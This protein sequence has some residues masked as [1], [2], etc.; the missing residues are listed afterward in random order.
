MPLQDNAPKLAPD[1][2]EKNFSDLY[3]PMAHD[4]AMAEASRCLFCYDAPCINACP[5]HIDIPKF[6]KQIATRN[7]KGSARTILAANLFGGSCAR[8]CP[9]EALCE[10]DCVMNDLHKKPIEIGRLQRFATDHVFGRGEH[11]KL[12]QKGASNGKKVAVIGAGPAGLS[13]AG[14]LAQLG[15]QV[16]VYDA[17]PKPGGLNTYAIAEYKMT[18]DTALKETEIVQA[19]GVTLKQGVQVGKD[20]SLSDLEKDND[21]VF[22]GIGL[23]KTAPLGIEGENMPGV[24]DA[25]TFIEQVKSRRFDKIELGRRVIV[26]GAGNTAVDATTQAKRLGAEKV[27]MLYRRGPDEMPA[28]DYEFDLAKRDGIEFLW[29][30]APKRIL[31][32]GRVERLECLRTKPKERGSAPE[33]V[34]GSEFAVECDMVIKALGQT[35]QKDFLQTL[36]GVKLDEKG[37]VIVDPATGQT[38]NPKFYAGGD[39]VNGGKEVVN[40]V[41]DGKRAAAAIH[42]NLLRQDVRLAGLST[43]GPIEYK[44]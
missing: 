22:V 29:Y 12:F 38:S 37:R 41:A 15:Y 19:L 18:M 27:V 10:G 26:I 30:T 28:Y 23:G 42:K 31:G 5:T 44:R 14:Y 11:T 7:I 13:C 8:V 2:Y 35:K 6:I 20:V 33:N 40:A 39:C 32:N 3:P 16:T 43:P 36:P 1:Q 25:L 17:R 4:E 24:M 21:A 34:P 9:V